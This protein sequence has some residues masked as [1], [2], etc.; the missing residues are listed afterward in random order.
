L[1]LLVLVLLPLLVLLLFGELLAGV[2]LLEEPL[3]FE[4]AAGAGCGGDDD[5]DACFTGG[6]GSPEFGVD[7]DARMCLGRAAGA[8]VFQTLTDLGARP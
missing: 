6:F 3:G 4:L 5:G 8:Q 2:A 7:E 1:L